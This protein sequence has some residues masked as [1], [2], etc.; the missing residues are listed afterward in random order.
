VRLAQSAILQSY[1]TAEANAKR[2]PVADIQTYV[3]QIQEDKNDGSNEYL[4]EIPA[5]SGQKYADSRQRNTEEMMDSESGILD[6]EMEQVQDQ[7]FVEARSQ[8]KREDSESESRVYKALDLEK[9]LKVW[10]DGAN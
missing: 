4:F 5:K 2:Q 3:G 7:T 6:S 9:R 1:A 10:G 8:R